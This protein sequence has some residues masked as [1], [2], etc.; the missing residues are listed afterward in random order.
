MRVDEWRASDS[1]RCRLRADRGVSYLSLRAQSI[2][3]Y[4][5]AMVDIQSSSG[6][7]ALTEPAQ[8]N[9]FGRR[10][11]SLL[12]L[13]GDDVLVLFSMPVA[14]RNNDV[15]HSYRQHSDFH[16][17]TGFVEP[18]SALVLGRECGFVLFLRPKDREKETWEGRRV[19]V[20]GASDWGANAAHPISELQKKLP[21]LLEDREGVHFPFGE[22]KSWDRTILDAVQEVRGRR[23]RRVSAPV[24]LQDA[25][26]LLHRA[27]W[28][29]SEFELELMR[30]AAAIS[31]RAHGEAM[32][33]CRPGMWEWQLQDVVENSFRAQGARRVAYESI[34]GSGPNATVLHYRE[35]DKKMLA[36]E[37]V[38]IDAGAEWGYYASDITRTFPVD[39]KF[40]PTAARVYQAVLE[41]QL[42][43]IEV[44]RVGA[45]V[46]QV[47]EAA[48]QVLRDALMEWGLLTGVD[49]ADEEA[50]KKRVNRFYMHRTSHYLGL[51][52]HDVGPYIVN[53]EPAPMEENVVITI[54]PGLYFAQDDDSVPEEYRGIGIRI[55]DD[56][57]VRSSGAWV[58]SADV[59]KTREGVEDACRSRL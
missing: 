37:L 32:A 4:D 18:E 15:E 11:Q 35:N 43:A 29:K 36:G 13:L 50:V 34:V 19:G 40:S 54:E 17:L 44:T 45:T 33:A 27:R 28:Q 5:W 12:E 20:E 21:D 59:P 57:V 53:K 2:L 6:S 49:L 39:G 38:L 52:V 56:V 51:D 31:A 55:E 41:A 26:A 46:E 58:L 14:L 10:R 25:R 22:Q 30:Q 8:M 23:R 42:A 1:G 24:R 3:R 7:A 47:H 9:E 16:Y 48:W